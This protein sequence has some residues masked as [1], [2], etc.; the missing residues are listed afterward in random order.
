MSLHWNCI[1]TLANMYMEIVEYLI[2]VNVILEFFQ[3]NWELIVLRKAPFATEHKILM[4]FFIQKY[5]SDQY[6]GSGTSIYI[7]NQKHV[8]E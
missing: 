7:I 2:Y 5:H 4:H 3:Q 6:L 8:H 1:G